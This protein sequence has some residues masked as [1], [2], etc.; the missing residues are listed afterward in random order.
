MGKKILKPDFKKECI[1]T[2]WPVI[3]LP[4]CSFCMKIRDMNNEWH[5][6][7]AYMKMY[8]GVEISH[9]ICRQC[10]KELYPQFDKEEP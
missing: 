7:E 1:N 6:M 3:I 5:F 8:F 4:M 9:G 2:G 10:A